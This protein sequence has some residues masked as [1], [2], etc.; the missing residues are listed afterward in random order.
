[1]SYYIGTKLVS[2]TPDTREGKEGYIVVYQDGYASWS[3]KKVFERAYLKVDDN[4]KLASGVSVGPKMVDDFIKEIHAETI[5]T[6]TT[7]VRVVLV[8]GFEIVESSSCVDE[9]NY[10]QS[11]G[12]ECCLERIKSKIWELLGFLLQTA[13]QGI[14]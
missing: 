12:I 9:A 5:G 14:K 3:P 11:I 8:N 10:S 7:L 13:Y 2:A 4:K 1:M 6:K